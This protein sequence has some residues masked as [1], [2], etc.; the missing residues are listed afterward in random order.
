MGYPGYLNCINVLG[1]HETKYTIGDTEFEGSFF[2][3]DGIY[4]NCAYVI[5]TTS[6]PS[7]PKDKLLAKQQKGWRK[8]VERAFG[9]LISK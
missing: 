1:V 5:K 6:Q 9:M 8:D 4:P 7:N 2:L 3:A